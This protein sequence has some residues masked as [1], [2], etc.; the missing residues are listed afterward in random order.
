MEL[1]LNQI[2]PGQGRSVPDP[3]YDDDG[4]EAVFQMLDRA[5]SAFVAEYLAKIKS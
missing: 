4:F 5:C 1:I 2:Y 3:F